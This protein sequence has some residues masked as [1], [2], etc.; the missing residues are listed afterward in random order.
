MK[1]IKRNILLNPGPATTTDTV[2]YSQVVPDICPRETEFGDLMKE[3]SYDLTTFVTA[4]PDEYTTVFF[5]GSGTSGVEAVVSSI[6]R[7]NDN[8]LVINNGA[9]GA[10]ILKMTEIYNYKTVEFKSSQYD[11]IDLAKLEKI[12]DENNINKLFMVHHETTTGLL[13]DIS[14]VGK[15]CKKYGVEL[16]VDTISSYAATPIDMD[17]MNLSYIV[18]TSNKNIQGMA[19]ISFVI[20]KKTILE[21]LSKIKPRNLYLNLY[22]QYKFMKK[23]TQLR[24]TPPVQTFYALKQA[25]AEAKEEGIENRYNR[26]RDCWK[27]LKEGLKDLNLEVLVDEKYQ[28]GLITTIVEPASSKYDFDKMHDFLYSKDITIYPGK[29]SDKSTFRIANIGAI[30]KADIQLFLKHLKEYLK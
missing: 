20:A 3:T 30:D 6:V 27:V 19:G 8:V 1:E 15:I 2:K 10:R 7:E 22:D 21:N 28:S 17:Q 16:A 11:G 29:V 26:Y 24:F 9:Y 12:I 4:N 18:S 23:S 5:G 14:S 13:N 25:I